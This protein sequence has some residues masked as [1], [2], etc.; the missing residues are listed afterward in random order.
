MDISS[1]V[2]VSLIV[3]AFVLFAG[4]LMYG[5]Y[6]TRLARQAQADKAAQTGLAPSSP[7]AE[8]RDAA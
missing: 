3:L 6:A 1:I 4:V 8:H 7:A 2:I 5:D